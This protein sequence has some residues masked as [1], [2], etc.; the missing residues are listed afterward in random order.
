MYINWDN[1]NESESINAVNKFKDSQPYFW[2]WVCQLNKLARQNDPE[3]RWELFGH[4]LVIESKDYD[5]CSRYVRLACEAIEAQYQC[6]TYS[7]LIEAGSVV[8]LPNLTQQVIIL[9]K[10]AW[11]L[12]ESEDP[13]SHAKCEK[14]DSLIKSLKGRAVTF[15]VVA[16]SYLDIAV[17]LRRE[18]LF[19]R[20]IHWNDPS[21]EWMVSELFESVNPEIFEQSVLDA[22]HRL[23]CL[24]QT[25]YSMPRK[26]GL[27]KSALKRLAYFENR[28]INWLD[29][30]RIVA[31]GTG[32]GCNI[33]KIADR[34]KIAAHEAGHALITLIESKGEHVPEITTVLPGKGYSGM[35]IDDYAY[36]DQAGDFLSL[37]EAYTKIRVALAG[38]AAEELIYGSA[39]V[40]IFLARDDLKQAT[41]IALDLVAKAGF[42]SRST[43]LEKEAYN[44]LVCKDD[45]YQQDEFYKNEARALLAEQ[46]KAVIT[47]LSEKRALLEKIIAALNDKK[48]LIQGDLRKIVDQFNCRPLI[49]T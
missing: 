47:S 27:L 6:L 33:P 25:E 23:G 10:G 43:S 42:T 49:H 11:Y 39:G 48:F 15:I 24:L 31:D 28:K 20:H 45:S 16:E 41:R 8:N 18:G 19:D 9:E 35:V 44:L 29:I 4:G 36:I 34:A 13:Q 7:Q 46:Y 1:K 5:L 37:Q 22:S 17:D 30:L 38:R 21:P 32:E 12:A 26:F 3:D 40:D 2:K 14:L